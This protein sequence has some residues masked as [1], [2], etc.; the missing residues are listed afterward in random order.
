MDEGLENVR[1]LH[2]R[3]RWKKETGKLKRKVYFYTIQFL[4]LVNLLLE[5]DKRSANVDDIP[6]SATNVCT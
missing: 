2:V 3:G 1:I 6:K 4:F 5:F